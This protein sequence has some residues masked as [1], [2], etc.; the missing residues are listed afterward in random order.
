[1]KATKRARI[2]KILHK[3]DS[4][5]GTHHRSRWNKAEQTKDG[6]NKQIKPPDKHKNTKIL[7]RGNPILCKIHTELIRE[8][9]QY[10]T[11][12]QKRNKMGMDRGTKHQ[13]QKYQ[14]RTNFSTVP[15]T[16]QRKQKKYRHHHCLRYRTRNSIVAETKQRRPKT[17]SLCKL[18]PKRRRKNIQSEN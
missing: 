16:L 13:L 11:I 5:A 3:G 1:M 10:A 14:E 17:N 2:I 12:T 9:R 15:R 8:N 6:S 7:F 4:L 18:L